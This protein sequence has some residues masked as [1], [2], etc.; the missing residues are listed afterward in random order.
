MLISLL[1][2]LGAG[3]V[4]IMGTWLIFWLISSTTRNAK[5]LD[6]AWPIGFILAVICYTYFGPADSIKKLVM[7]AMV[8]LW[9]GRLLWHLI[10][11]YQPRTEDLRFQEIEVM[12]GKE[13]AGLKYLLLCLFQ[14]LMAIILTL[15]FIIISLNS[16]SQW[17]WAEI[18]AICLWAIALVC[19]SLADQQLDLFRRDPVNVNQVCQVGFW[20]HS[21]H[22]NFFF[23]WLTWVAFFLFAMPAEGGALAIMS[24]IIVF[25]IFQKMTIPL[26]ESQ[27]LKT[28]GDL[29]RNYQ[30]TTSSF[31]PWFR[32]NIKSSTQISKLPSEEG[33]KP[34]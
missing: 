7:A 14:G 6:Y 33:K 25:I 2:M 5:F 24:P 30:K 26:S 29:Y 32:K 31:F 1:T 28:K 20:G 27:S 15:P 17:H 10:T 3:F 11:R 23:E 16:T 12:L 22:P 8:F 4:S 13:M 19:E 9:T 21:R 18:V 34:L